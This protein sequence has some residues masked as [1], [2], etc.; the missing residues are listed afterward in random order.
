MVIHGVLHLL[1]MDHQVEADAAAME[2]CE[3]TMLITL[4]YQNP[5]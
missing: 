4:G 3:S 2:K 1:G 5:Y